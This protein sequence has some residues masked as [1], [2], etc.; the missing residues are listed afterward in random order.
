MLHFK[1]KH[2]L[3]W[4]LTVWSAPVLIF[5]MML[6]YLDYE[7]LSWSLV[8]APPMCIAF[9]AFFEALLKPESRRQ[10]LKLWAGCTVLTFILPALLSMGDIPRDERVFRRIG[11]DIEPPPASMQERRAALR[12]PAIFPSGH[13]VEHTSKFWTQLTVKESPPFTSG[14]IVAWQAHEEPFKVTFPV[15][16]SEAPPKLPNVFKVDT[17]EEAEIHEGTFAFTL[18]VKTSAQA[19]V[20]LLEEEHKFTITIDPG[21]KPHA[22]RYVAFVVKDY[23]SE[24]FAGMTVTVNETP[25]PITLA[26]YNLL[27]PGD[28]EPVSDLKLV[29]NYQAFAPEELEF[30]RTFADDNREYKYWVKTP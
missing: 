3:R 9:A 30:K 5:M 14:Q 13:H 27:R 10:T 26:G 7:K 1:A 17:F 18:K 4:T 22:E 2:Q 8:A 15:F 21:P 19:T 24:R 12:L 20:K 29:T 28:D 25:I 6:A 23:V 11:P 16:A